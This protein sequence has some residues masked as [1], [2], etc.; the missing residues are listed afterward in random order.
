MRMWLL[1]IEP[2]SYGKRCQ[3]IPQL[4]KNGHFIRQLRMLPFKT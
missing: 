4:S 1:L 3:L 2:L